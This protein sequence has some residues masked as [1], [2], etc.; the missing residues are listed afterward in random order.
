MKIILFLI[1]IALLVWALNTYYGKHTHKYETARHYVYQG[2]ILLSISFIVL[3]ISIVLP[4]N[5]NNRNNVKLRPKF[6][7]PV[8]YTSI[9]GANIHNPNNDYPSIRSKN[10][11]KNGHAQFNLYTHKDTSINNISS[12]NDTNIIK[13]KPNHY[14]VR[15]TYNRANDN[16]IGYKHKI[17]AKSA[18][19]R[20]N[21]INFR[22]N[23]N[24]AEKK[25][26][27]Q[28]K[29]EQQAKQM[30]TIKR[31]ERIQAQKRQRFN[32]E[33]IEITGKSWNTLKHKYPALSPTEDLMGGTYASLSGSTDINRIHGTVVDVSSY[34]NQTQLLVSINH[35]DH[36]MYIK[37]GSDNTKYDETRW[38]HNIH[39]GDHIIAF[40]DDFYKNEKV[41]NKMIKQGINK[42]YD[43]KT[44]YTLTSPEY[45]LDNI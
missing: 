3:I 31:D 11:N 36:L 19:H 2:N 17:I 37:T 42:K 10:F 22:L 21:Y 5:S 14:Q 43:G 32:N 34:G 23:D 35:L 24:K 38:N 18:H 28:K 44:I 30:R 39:V 4:S 20:P 12:N 29:Q 15:F 6:Q 40:G 16:G 13:I 45:I 7:E 27:Q 33:A 25:Y 8:T 26:Y 9:D 41:T 1:F